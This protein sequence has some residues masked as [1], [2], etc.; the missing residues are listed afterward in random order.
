M[1][2]KVFI[3]SFIIVLASGLYYRNTI[4]RLYQGH[5]DMQ[6]SK[7]R[8]KY[9]LTNNGSDIQDITQA[10]ISDET[11]PDDLKQPLINGER[12]IVVFKYLSGSE[13]VAGYLSYLTTGSH[14]VLIFLRGGNGYYGVMRPNNRF[15][16]F[17]DHNVVG[18][19][20]RGNIYGGADEFGGNDILDV[21]NL[22]KF[23]P[24]LEHF[25]HIKMQPPYTMMG[26]SRGAMEMFISLGR[27][28]Y[29]KS[30][31]NRAISVSGNVDLKISMKNRPEMNYLFSRQYKSSKAKSF[32]EWV[33][34][35][36]P[37]ENVAALSK[38]LKVL[39]IYGLDDNRVSLEEQTSLMKALNEA[40]IENKLA[41]IQ[42]ANHGLDE[43][44]DDFEKIATNSM[45]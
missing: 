35:R 32:D 14:P 27:S 2:R 11:V 45:K 26:V 21:E 1:F 31:V 18:T 23:F 17:K 40:G 9:Y 10:I 38:S 37:V 39:L 28:N 6:K 43:H 41:T 22:L 15:S 8:A 34:V 30:K 19:L 36:N 42:G 7:E 16:F 13:Y 3:V 4:L 33:R 5:I 29:V 12:R 24:E 44:Y 25:S 20:Y